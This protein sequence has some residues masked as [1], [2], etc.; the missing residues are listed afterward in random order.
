[1]SLIEQK[2]NKILDVPPKLQVVRECMLWLLM[3]H[4]DIDSE[5][6]VERAEINSSSGT[7]KLIFTITICK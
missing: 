7:N 5:I 3:K 1:M 4:A 6:E 2:I